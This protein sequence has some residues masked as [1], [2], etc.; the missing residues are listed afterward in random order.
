[1]D[2]PGNYMDKKY[3]VGTIIFMPP[4]PSVKS[5]KALRMFKKLSDSELIAYCAANSNSQKALEA[6]FRRFNKYIDKRI[7][8]VLKS[9]NIYDKDSH[10][11]VKCEL[12]KKIKDGRLLAEAIKRE[13]PKAWIGKSVKHL[14]IDWRRK[15]NKLENA[16]KNLGEKGALS[17]SE[18]VGDEDKR[19]R[20]DFIINPD[21]E[22]LKEIKEQTGILF[23]RIEEL[24]ENYR[25]TLKAA[26]MLYKPLTC[27]IIT[28][29]ANKR[30]RSYEAIEQ[31]ISRIR[32]PLIERSNE[33][34]TLQHKAAN[35]WAR[36]KKLEQQRFLLLQNKDSHQKRILAL[37]EI[38]HKLKNNP[39]EKNSERIALYKK[40]IAAM[41]ADLEKIE[42]LKKEIKKKEEN[43]DNNLKRCRSFI[44]PTAK[45]IS[46][47]L[48]MSQDNVSYIN[49]LLKRARGI[50]KE[51]Q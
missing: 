4:L 41:Q 8:T 17:L 5:E 39:A 27:K 51:H 6:F 18:T 25:L 50:L 26:I 21:D 15:H 24:G 9:A 48:E 32:K 44:R 45:Q 13:D 1:M 12:I 7:K 40:Q 28:E 29:I 30:K 19:V 35:L 31:E 43:R 46:D 49:T 20:E 11:D 38:V 22:Q 36:I 10:F 33:N 2:L 3:P 42:E 16:Y 37:Q 34:L 14:T 47:L 23:E